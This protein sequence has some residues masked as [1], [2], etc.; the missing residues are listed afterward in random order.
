[1]HPA[2][3]PA[4]VGALAQVQAV[5]LARL[6]TAASTSNVQGAGSD[7]NLSVEEAADR[8]R[9]SKDYLYRQAHRLPFT[10]R[11][12]RK[13]LFSAKGLEKWNAQRTRANRY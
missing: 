2:E 3:L 12:G 10:V 1:V 11:I 6:T 7:Y 8:L 5:A 4:V 9:V 13:L